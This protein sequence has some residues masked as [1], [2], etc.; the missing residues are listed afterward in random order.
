M[1]RKFAQLEFNFEMRLEE[2]QTF[3]N[4]LTETVEELRDSCH[5]SSHDKSSRITEN[6]GS[7]SKSHHSDK[8]DNE[9]SIQSMKSNSENFVG[10][11]ATAKDNKDYTDGDPIIFDVVHLNAGDGYD[12]ELNVF[13]CPV[14]GFYFF[15]VTLASA[16]DGN[17]NYGRVDCKIVV[18]SSTQVKAIA[19]HHSDITQGTALGIYRCEINQQVYIEADVSDQQTETDGEGVYGGAHSAFSG[20][21]ISADST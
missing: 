6:T 12:T 1:E 19:N 8:P 9:H 15:S 2:K 11:M 21:L 5:T 16:D 13:N 17:D 10:F 3:I 20:F 4:E 14:S 18:A 7:I